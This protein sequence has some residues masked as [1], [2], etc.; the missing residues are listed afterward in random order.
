M[1]ELQSQLVIFS[2]FLAVLGAFWWLFIH[3]AHRRRRL[4]S[5]PFPAEWLAMLR[6]TLPW[7]DRMTREEQQALQN[8]IKRFLDEKV[9]V[10]CAGQPVND[11]VRLSIAA[12]AC[13]LLLHRQGEG[14]ADLKYILVYPAE[15]RVNR[16]VQDDAGLVSHDRSILAGESWEDGRIVLS[17]DNVEEGMADLGDGYNVVLHEFAHQLDQATG[18]ANGAPALDAKQGYETWSRVMSAAFEQLEHAAE[19]GQPSLFDYYGAT[20]PAEFFAVA[21]EVFYEKPAAM[22]DQHPD[23]FAQLLGYYRVDPRKWH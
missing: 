18:F 6:R 4:D 8:L 16:P 13:L 20:D 15:F 1:T 3:P 9:F 21:T 17:W 2:L 22:A 11:A 23:V 5:Q 10:P 14:Y 19:A 7:Y 12:Q